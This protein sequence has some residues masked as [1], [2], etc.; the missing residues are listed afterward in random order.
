MEDPETFYEPWTAIQRYRRVQ[1]PYGEQVCAEGN[2]RDP[3][4]DYNV[5]TA[6]KPDF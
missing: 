5:P 6:D 4:F 3:F 1:R 2:A